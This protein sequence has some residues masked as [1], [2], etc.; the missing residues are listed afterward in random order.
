MSA[1]VIRQIPDPP[2]TARRNPF[3]LPGLDRPD[4]FFLVCVGAFGTAFLTLF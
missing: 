2:Q 3:E 1:T 4:I